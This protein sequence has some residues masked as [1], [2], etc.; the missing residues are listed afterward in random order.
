MEELIKTLGIL[1]AGFFI[2][3][4]VDFLKNLKKDS[5]PSEIPR[6]DETLEK[7]EEIDNRAKTEDLVTRVKRFSDLFR[8]RIGR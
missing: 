8:R 6:E 4:V 5:E 1:A 3:V 7:Y 2:G